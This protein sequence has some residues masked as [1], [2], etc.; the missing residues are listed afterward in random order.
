MRAFGVFLLTCL[1]SGALFGQAQAGFERGVNA[2]RR[3]QYAE[4]E[5][6]WRE[7]LQED[8]SEAG[9]ARVYYNLGNAAW[10]QDEA[11]EAVGWYSACLRISPRHGDAWNNLEFVRADAG[12]EPADRGDLRS[13]ARR[14]LLALRPAESRLLAFSALGVLGVL[15]LLEAF[16]GGALFRLLC[17]LGAVGT[18]VL[19]MPFF[20]RLGNDARDPMLV[21]RAPRVAI[22]AEPNTQRDQIGELEAGEEVERIDSLPGWVRVTGSEGTNGWVQEEALFPLRP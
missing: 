2:Y 13:T 3:G 16:V 12:L 10:R 5:V 21:V 8:L 14:A 9:R 1:F 11:M 19:C 18:L 22:R 4:A 17:A 15:F 6:L 20:Y 7:T